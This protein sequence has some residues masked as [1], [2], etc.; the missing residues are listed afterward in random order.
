M[1]SII[2]KKSIIVISLILIISIILTSFTNIA[3][4]GFTYDGIRINGI[5]DLANLAESNPEKFMQIPYSTLK[6]NVLVAEIGNHQKNLLCVE[7][8]V[9]SSKYGD[10]KIFRVVDINT[11]GPNTAIING[12]KLNLSEDEKI[13]FN[14]LAEATRRSTVDAP[15]I[16]LAHGR[17]N[18]P[19]KSV[20]DYLCNTAP[21][22]SRLGLSGCVTGAAILT[23]EGYDGSGNGDQLPGFS[24]AIANGTAT[25][26]G[27]YGTV[28]EVASST[29]METKVSGNDIFIGP[30]QYEYSEKDKKVTFYGIE[31]NG[32][33]DNGQSVY[34]KTIDPNKEEALY[35]STSKGFVAVNNGT[36][37]QN[38]DFYIKVDSKANDAA[39][40]KVNISIA[41]PKYYKSRIVLIG[42]EANDP[43]SQ[44]IAVYSVGGGAET[45]TDQ[46]LEYEFE[47]NR[48]KIEINKKG[49][50]AGTI[51]NNV[52]N[53]GFKIYY[54]EKNKKQYL[55]LTTVK[56]KV[57]GNVTIKKQEVSDEKDA[58]ILYADSEGELIIDKIDSRYDYYLE[59]VVDKTEY[60]AEVLE[61]SQ[62]LETD[63]EKESSV[64]S[65]EKNVIGPITVEKRSKSKSTKVT[66]S[67]THKTGNI[68]LVKSDYD[69]T[70][71]KLSGIKFK[72]RNSVTKQWVVAEGKDGVYNLKTYDSDYSKNK[73]Y[74]KD[75]YTS[76]ENKATEFETNANGEII[77]NGVDTGTYVFKEVYI[78]NNNGNMNYGYTL[79][80]E[81]SSIDKNYVFWST[82]EGKTKNK[83][84][85]KKIKLTVV[86]DEKAPLCTI[87]LYNKK[88]YI[89]ITGLVWEDIATDEVKSSENAYKKYGQDTYKEGDKLVE[90]IEV[91]LKNKNGETVKQTNTSEEKGKYT[92]T[93]VSREAV[94]NGEYYVEFE[95]N[96]LTYTSVLTLVGNDNS[97]NSKAG[98]DSEQRKKLNKAFTE[99]TNKGNISDRNHGYSRNSTNASDGNKNITGEL[100]YT[101]DFETFTSKFN[102][103]NTPYDKPDTTS[104][105]YNNETYSGVNLTAN[106]NISNNPDK[107][108]TYSLQKELNEG[109]IEI[110]ETGALVIPHVNLGL[111]RRAQPYVSLSNDIEN[112]RIDINGYS[113]R[114]DYNQRSSAVQDGSAFNVGVKFGEKYT[115]TYRRAIYPSDIPGNKQGSGKDEENKLKVYVTYATTIGNRSPELKAS[116]NELV[117][118]YDQKYYDNEYT[119]VDSWIG[120]NVD[121]KVTWNTS[122]KYGQSFKDE[123]GKDNKYNAIY[124]TSTA[125]TVINPMESLV[126]HITFRVSDEAVLGLL[127][128]T[129]TLDNV[130]EIYSYSTYY[131]SNKE[132]CATGDIYAG[133]DVQSAPGNATPTDTKTFEADTDCAPS[134]ILEAKGARMIE[135]NVFEDSTASDLQTGKERKGDGEFKTGENT[136]SGVKVELLD[137]D[138]IIA[139]IYPSLTNDSG[140]VVNPDGEKEDAVIKATGEDGHYIF[141]GIEPGV[142]YI[143]YTYGV[144]KNGEEEI[145]TKVIDASG[146]EVKDINVQNYKS[147]IIT[148]NILTQAFENNDN[149][150][151][152]Y[153]EEKKDSNYSGQ[154]YSD[155][156]DIYSQ[157]QEIDK[158]L[159]AL[160][161]T[162]TT[163]IKSINAETPRFDLGVEY[164]TIY[165]ASAGDSYEYKVSNMDF[166]IVERPRQA[167][168]VNKDI[169]KIIVKSDTGASIGGEVDIKNKVIPEH[170][171]LLDDGRLLIYIGKED[172]DGSNI[173]LDYA[174]SL[175]NA[176][177]IDYISPEYYYYGTQTG[178]PVK[179]SSATLVDYIDKDLLMQSGQEDKWT[180]IGSVEGFSDKGFG[181]KLDKEHEEK[182]LKEFSSVAKT[183]SISTGEHLAAGET[184]KEAKH[185][186]VEKLLDN[187][188]KEF[189]YGNNCELVKVEKNGG[190]NY[191]YQLSNYAAKLADNPEA[192]W[193]EPDENNVNG[194]AGIKG[195]TVEISQNFG[196]NRSTLYIII[197]VS[198][199]AILGVGIFATRKFLKK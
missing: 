65:S 72:V 135:G 66:I 148:S 99:I 195:L 154:R 117:N 138:G 85:D 37:E 62:K 120:D 86:E 68:K 112:V 157:R 55:K 32:E 196:E 114:Y 124:T 169:T 44:T 159:T 98:E 158:E 125:G 26:N 76:D 181:W 153:R 152:W 15:N 187:D 46:K 144:Y 127:N 18:A 6:D 49:I 88:K 8:G 129:P 81:P 40:I 25:A 106:T 150:L 54:L 170:M 36:I 192:Q 4:A 70:K 137:K 145:V 48:G 71:T 108:E 175:T 52:S 31:V 143:R 92:F 186:V 93:E 198:G 29:E 103:T 3:S 163:S 45:K 174:L 2:N 21:L 123:A 50:Y 34:T 130:S 173:Q 133:I 59:E 162:S 113:H 188:A 97:I 60:E 83:W 16:P 160:D 101:N 58:T 11:E 89:K 141:R 161:G 149:N 94:E 193:A 78:N 104:T 17:E 139:Q 172:I 140:V 184:S 38:K 23:A 155:A 132:G 121:N 182:L 134:L 51:K 191:Y 156:R 69:N 194:P 12:A 178:T 33:D 74:Y 111:L 9:G 90:G 30:F 24:E 165:T 73:E 67:D 146:K 43:Y 179:F 151:T 115:S 177:E 42:A 197:A 84:A 56:D 28:K 164:E 63:G 41:G 167:A 80:D 61:A 189:I 39:K 79:T 22:E 109:R 64:K 171:Q 185:I 57:K 183:E 27:S 119:I 142:Y 105:T 190:A 53:M 126:V 199:L 1:S 82:D 87:Y 20:I 95:Y 168:I 176:S 7:H 128:G 13:H 147:T 107:K 116:V 14:A 122:S 180:V 75:N 96:G 47:N 77:I 100:T 91:R 118:Y 5:V 19:W 136:I 35:K 166:G 110:D 10:K 102:S 131:G